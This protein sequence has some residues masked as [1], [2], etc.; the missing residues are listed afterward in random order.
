MRTVRTTSGT[1]AVQIVRSSRRGSRQIEHLGSAHD[2][3]ELEAL[4][5]AAEQRIAAGQLAPASYRTLKR[6]L[7][8]YAEEGWRQQLSE[9]CGADVFASQH[10]HDRDRRP[11]SGWLASG[12]SP[13]GGKIPAVR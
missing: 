3:A 5:A 8:A 7:P 10:V 6:R 1:T 12:I 11:G 4:K 13:G 2:E 9:A